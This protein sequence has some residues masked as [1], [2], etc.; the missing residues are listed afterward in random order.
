MDGKKRPE[1]QQSVAIRTRNHNIYIAGDRSG[2]FDDGEAL[3]P[4]IFWKKL[5]QIVSMATAVAKE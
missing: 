2:V 5:Q 1:Q 3:D 4:K